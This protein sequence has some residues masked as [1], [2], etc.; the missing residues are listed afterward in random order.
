MRQTVYD[1]YAYAS[2]QPE[3][4]QLSKLYKT[5][6]I[7]KKLFCLLSSS[8]ESQGNSGSESEDIF[9]YVWLRKQKPCVISLLADQA[10]PAHR[11]STTTGAFVSQSLSRV[12][13]NQLQNSQVI[14]CNKVGGNTGQ[15]HSQYVVWMCNHPISGSWVNI[16][17]DLKPD[18]AYLVFVLAQQ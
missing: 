5:M 6:A 8:A 12:L 13:T 18:S 1:K 11:I 9:D 16:Y 17:G 3:L 7:Q 2:Y 15:G 10:W 4:L 14:I